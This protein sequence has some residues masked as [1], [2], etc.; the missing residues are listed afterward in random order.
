MKRGEII[1]RVVSALM[2]ITFMAWVH[3]EPDAELWGVAMTSILMYEAL[4]VSL[5]YICKVNRRRTREE[6]IR[7]N[8]RARKED[9]E[10]LEEMN[11]NPLMEVICNE[12]NCVWHDRCYP[13]D[14]A[15]VRGL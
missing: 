11:F 2:T 7:L 13:D 14:F 8:L 4:R 3:P 15:G 9:A 1:N 6:Y 12:E 5:D 10:R